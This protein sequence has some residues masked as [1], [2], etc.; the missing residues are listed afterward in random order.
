MATGTWEKLRMLVSKQFSIHQRHIKPDT[1][2]YADL[3][4]DELDILNLSIR[5]EETFNIHIPNEKLA[6]LRGRA[7]GIVA[8]I[9]MLSCEQ[10]PARTLGT[11]NSQ[12]K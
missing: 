9:A 4:A 2:I 10:R 11:L 6:T 1:N 12:G 5:V 8:L 3:G 7:E